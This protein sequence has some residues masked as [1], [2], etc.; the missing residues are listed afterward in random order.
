MAVLQG[1][2]VIG[3]PDFEA[4]FLAALGLLFDRLMSRPALTTDS[5]TLFVLSKPT[6]KL[7]AFNLEGAIAAAAANA[8]D[9]TRQ[10]SPV[11]TRE[12]L[13]TAF[14]PLCG[15]SVVSEQESGMTSEFDWGEVDVDIDFECISPFGP[16][17]APSADPHLLPA[18]TA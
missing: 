17:D 6:R 3:I 2:A 4:A 7:E 1:S 18:L 14:D 11:E 8:E 10:L 9:A 13:A 16:S 15:T 12:L 5:E